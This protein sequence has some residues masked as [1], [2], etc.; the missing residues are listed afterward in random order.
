MGLPVKFSVTED[1]IPL[2][3][4]NLTTYRDQTRVLFITYSQNIFT[5]V[6]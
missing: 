2:G 4:C 3:L 5:V 1:E 6:I